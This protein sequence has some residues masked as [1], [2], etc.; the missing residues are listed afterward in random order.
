MKKLGIILSA[1]YLVPALACPLSEE[2]FQQKMDQMTQMDH[3]PQTGQ[4]NP[5]SLKSLSPGSLIPPGAISQEKFLEL[6]TRTRAVYGP[7][8]K[9]LKL[10]LSVEANWQNPDKNAYAFRRGKN[11]I[12]IL[13]GG[14]AR[15]NFM[16]PDAYLAVICHE[17]GHH[18]GGYPK[19]NSSWWASSEGQADYFATLKCMKNMLRGDKDNFAIS[20][21]LELP[22]QVKHECY[23]QY[24]MSGEN[25]NICLRSAKAAEDFGRALHHNRSLPDVERISLMNR[26]DR[27][28]AVTEVGHPDPQCRV[29]T[30]YQGALCNLPPT[31]P[32]DYKDELKGTCHERKGHQLGTRPACWFSSI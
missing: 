8:F 4:L 28:V 24:R 17:I 20:R 23:R 5:P 16:T 22:T 10:N 6:A 7:I 21:K 13:S 9:K 3:M 12:V 14:F 19:L 15:I 18:L 11:A 30:M 1:C 32:L 2:D 26:S 29:D 25:Y 27:A 31:I